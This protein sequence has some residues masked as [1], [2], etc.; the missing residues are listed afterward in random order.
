MTSDTGERVLAGIITEEHPSC[1]VESAPLT[2][3]ARIPLADLGLLNRALTR[4]GYL[5]IPAAPTEVER[6]RVSRNLDQISWMP[7]DVLPELVLRYEAV[8]QDGTTLCETSGI[9]RGCTIPTAS[10]DDGVFVRAINERGDFSEVAATN[11]SAGTIRATDRSKHSVEEAGH[12]LVTVCTPSNWRKYRLSSTDPKG[13]RL[14]LLPIVASQS[15]E[16]PKGRRFLTT[17]HLRPSPEL[18]YPHGIY[19]L[20]IVGPAIDRISFSLHIGKS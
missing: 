19:W 13:S 5:Q 20:R 12:I 7:P 9:K 6:L 15:P 17:F 18:K 3:R 2:T 14:T 8:S 11:V 16:C 1:S 10:I 4:A